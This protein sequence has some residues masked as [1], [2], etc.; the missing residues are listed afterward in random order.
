MDNAKKYGYKF[1]IIYGYTFEKAIIFKEYVEFLYQI[2]STYQSGDALYLIAKI[3]LNSLYGRFGM[4]EIVMKYEIITKE[5]S[6]EIPEDKI[7]D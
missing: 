3:L 5:Q 2:K 6:L 4:N 1:E 7:L